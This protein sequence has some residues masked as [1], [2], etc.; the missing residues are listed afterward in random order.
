M[1]ITCLKIDLKKVKSF[2][3]H[4]PLR[5]EHGGRNCLEELYTKTRLKRQLSFQFCDVTFKWSIDF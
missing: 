4:T 3:A 2:T 5:Y 1:S